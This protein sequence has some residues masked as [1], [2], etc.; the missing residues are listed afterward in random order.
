MALVNCPECG[1]SNVSDT[2]VSCPECGFAIKEYFDKVKAEEQRI[3][4]EKTMKRI[5]EKEEQRK[6]RH[7][8]KEAKRDYFPIGNADRKILKRNKEFSYWLN[9]HL[10]PYHYVLVL[11]Q[12][13]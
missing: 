10:T 5:K 12:S 3:S 11:E 8:R 4:N 13:R 1:K 9:Y 6:K 7:S 2:A